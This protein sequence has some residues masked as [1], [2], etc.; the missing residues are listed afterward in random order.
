MKGERAI[1]I[2]GEEFKFCCA[3]FVAYEGFRERLH[4]HNYTVEVE[5]AGPMSSRDGYVIDFG[6]VKRAIRVICKRLNERIIIPLESKH[7]H[8]NIKPHNSSSGTKVV[9]CSDASIDD[10]DPTEGQV[11]VTCLDSAFFSFPLSDC[12]LLP[13]GFST[14]ESLSAFVANK[15]EETLLRDISNRGIES[16]TVRVFERPSQA[17]A[18]TVII[19]SQ[20]DRS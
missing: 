19:S 13:I 11:E 14:A 2:R 1:T 17:A 9:M 10:V 4:G 20:K 15:L 6:D 16:L 5:M 12:A 8:I 7:L 3:H 18:Y